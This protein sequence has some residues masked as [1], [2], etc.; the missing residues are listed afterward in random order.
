MAKA[1]DKEVATTGEQLP[2]FMQDMDMGDN[3]GSEDVGKEDITIPRLEI[4]QSLSP[5]RDKN[6]PAYIEGCEDGDL[7]N[8]VTRELYGPSVDILFVMFK[9]QWLVWK[10]RKAGGG[11]RGEFPTQ[12][13]A[14]DKIVE[15]TNE[16]DAGPWDAIDTAQHVALVVREDGR[17]EEIGVS[18][19]KSKMKVSR[20]LNTMIRLAGGPRWA[21]VYKVSAVME[22]NNDGDKYYNYHITQMGFVQNE[23]QFNAAEKL[24]EDI[25]SGEREVKVAQEDGTDGHAEDG[26]GADAK[27]QF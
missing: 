10:D 18:M 16:G 21:R 24:Y 22:T 19:S 1:K 11:F 20:N 12:Q 15:L 3:R 5:C 14:N 6:D 25:H 26:A 9:K 8:S 4:V 17:T 2:A 13:D 23:D 7:Y 27:G